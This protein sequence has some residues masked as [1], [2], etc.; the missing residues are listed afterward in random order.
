MMESIEDDGR[1]G[2]IGKC[3]CEHETDLSLVELVAARFP[4]VEKPGGHDFN[5]AESRVDTS[6]SAS[7]LGYRRP[8]DVSNV[9]AMRSPFISIESYWASL[10]F[11][12]LPE[13][14]IVQCL[15][16]SRPPF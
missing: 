1:R 5:G 9:Q 13:V 14:K 12:K 8:A 15:A 11:V 10:I 6:L 2:K 7:A 16:R 4:A 3:F